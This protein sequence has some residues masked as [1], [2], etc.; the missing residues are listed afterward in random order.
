MRPYEDILSPV[1]KIKHY[2]IAYDGLAKDIKY[3]VRFSAIITVT[4]VNFLQNVITMNSSGRSWHERASVLTHWGWDN[5][6]AICSHWQTT[7]SNVFSW[8]IFNEFRFKFQ[9][10]LKGPISSIPALVQMMASRRL[11]DKPL[12]E[13]MVVRLPTPRCVTRPQW[14]N[15]VRLS[16]DYMRH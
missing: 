7:F 14:V 10:V 11:R 1:C 16:N 6:A 15:N 3:H 8:M 4:T 2:R 9:F 12:S 5:M 13:P